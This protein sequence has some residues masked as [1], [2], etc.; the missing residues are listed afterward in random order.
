MSKQKLTPWFPDDVKPARRGVYRVDPFSGDSW[1]AYFDGEK[2]GWH[3]LS[4]EGAYDM[5]KEKTGCAPDQRWR[6]LAQE[7][8]VQP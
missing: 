7:P 2:F 6:G 1:Y 4:P 8:R 3:G 5:R